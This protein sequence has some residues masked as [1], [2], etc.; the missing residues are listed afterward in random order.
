MPL[1]CLASRVQT[2]TTAVRCLRLYRFHPDRTYT[3]LLPSPLS[4][5]LLGGEE[6]GSK[7]GSCALGGDD[8]ILAAGDEMCPGVRIRDSHQRRA[9]SSTRHS[10]SRLQT[11]TTTAKAT[12]GVH[13]RHWP[14]PTLPQASLGEG[15]RGEEERMFVE[16]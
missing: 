12:I 9:F 8:L 14:T 3:L 16:S 5:L 10:G 4:T 7:V 11:T 13:S 1:A 15:Y 6:R 2:A